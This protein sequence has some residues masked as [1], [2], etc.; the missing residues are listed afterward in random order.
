[1]KSAISLLPEEEA[2]YE[3]SVLTPQGGV[4]LVSE[5]RPKLI[6]LTHADIA[7]IPDEAG[8]TLTGI[9]YL[10]QVATGERQLGVIVSNRRIPCF[11]APEYE[12]VVRDLIPGSLVEVE[13]RATLDERGQVHRIEDVVDVRPVQLVPLYWSRIVYGN[14]RFHLR[15]HIQIQVDFRDGL[16]I[17]EYAPLGILAYAETRAESLNAFR[18]DFAACWDFLAQEGDHGLTEDARVLKAKLLSLVERIEE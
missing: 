7:E 4:K 6:G 10:I 8:R 16:W 12:D 3:L 2:D 15:E 17:H 9:L 18:M 11:Y 14:R 13:G 1:M 5:L